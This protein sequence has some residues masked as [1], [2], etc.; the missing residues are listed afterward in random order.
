[1]GI[2]NGSRVA[3]GKPKIGGG[4]WWAPASA[5]E[6]TDATTALPAEYIC[7]GPISDQ[8]V[9]PVRDANTQVVKEWG[10]DSLED[11]LTDENRAFEADLLGFNDVDVLKF[12]YSA[13]NV[14]TTAATSTKGTTITVLDKGGLLPEGHLVVETN[15]RGAAT[16]EVVG[17]A[18]P[19]I[20]GERPA[21]TNDLRGWTVRTTAKRAADG[22]FVKRYTELADK[23]A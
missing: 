13:A 11:L 10:G 7:L 19:T 23:T 22:T 1:M 5:P 6:P 8:G 21:I 20:T 14:T 4:L 17:I 2:N 15:H 18:A 12:V 3:S 9:R 16:R